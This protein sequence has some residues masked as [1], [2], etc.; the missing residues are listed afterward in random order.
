M[1]L[2]LHQRDQQ[3]EAL[4]QEHLD[5]LK[6]FTSTQETLQTR[7]QSLGDLQVRYDELQARDRCPVREAAQAAP[8]ILKGSARLPSCILCCLLSREAPASLLPPCNL[9]TGLASRAGV[10]PP[11]WLGQRA[12]CLLGFCPLSGLHVPSKASPFPQIL[13]R[14][15]PAVQP[16]PSLVGD[17]LSVNL[18]EAQGHLQA[19]RGGH[20]RGDHQGHGFL[21]VPVDG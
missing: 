13:P 1:K 16:T 17:P 20:L 19:A 6:Q 15:T 18:L 21:R 5:L 9:R 12:A 8:G 14:M 11:A 3:L 4:Q 10:Q 2:T 7:E